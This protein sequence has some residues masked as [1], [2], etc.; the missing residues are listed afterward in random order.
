MSRYTGA[1]CKICRREGQKLFLKGERCYT[2]KCA[3]EQRAYPP[4][5]HGQGRVRVTEYRLHLRE[6]QKVRYT[7]GVSES[8]FRRYYDMAKR[9]RGVTG[10]QLLQLLERRLDNI[11]YRMGFSSSRNAARQLINHGHILVNG[12]KVDIPSYLVKA[13]DVV[14]VKE[15]SKKMESIGASLEN[16]E[17]RGFAE[18]LEVDKEARRGRIKALP[19]RKDMPTSIQETLIIEFYSK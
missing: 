7:Y 10:E 16:R 6:K 4:G 19:E 18:W 5:Q 1:V 3:I 17:Q 2:D 15:K 11:V 9:T 13:G 14:E 12:R 8:Q